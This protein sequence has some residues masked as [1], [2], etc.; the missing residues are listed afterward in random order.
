MQKTRQEL[1][2]IRA[3]CDKDL[4][5]FTRFF[6]K[7]LRG[8]KFIVNHHHETIRNNLNKIENYELELLNINIP[9]RFSKC[10][11][12]DT[13][14]M[15]AEGLK[16]A[17]NVTNSDKLYTYDQGNL[18]IEQCLGTETAY[19]N[20]VK[21]TMRS[22]RAITCST[23]HPML[24]TFGYKEA[25]D[26]S[27]G[28]RIKAIRTKIDA[29]YEIDYNE[30][31][32][33]T[34]MIFEGNCYKRNLRFSNNDK[35]IVDLFHKVC[36]ELKIGVKQ[37]D[38]SASYDYN[39]LGGL[40]GNAFNILQKYGIY[41][42]KSYTKRL[43]LDWFNL[44]YGQ[45]LVFIDLMFATDGYVNSSNGS[46]GVCLANKG[47][48]VDI[49]QILATVGIISTIHEKPNDYAGAWSLTVTRFETQKLTEM[50]SFYHKR[51]KAM[52]SHNNKAVFI[53]DS[54]PY[55]II[56]FEK[57]TYKTRKDGLRCE[58]TKDITREKFNRLR[59]KYECLNK[60]VDND[61][62]LDK[63]V[64]IEKVGKKKL[65]HLE[66][67]RTKNFIANGLVSHNTELAAVNL[68]ARG[69]GMNPSSNYLY[70][71]ASDELRSQTSVS[72]RDIVTHPYF[73]IMYGVELKKDQ[74]AKN[75]WRTEQGGGLKTATIFGQITGFGAGQMKLY[76]G[77]EDLI[78]DFEGCIVIDDANKTD[79]SEVENSN[80]D[81]VSRVFFNTILSRKN[82][83]DTPI[84]NIQQRAGLSDLTAQLEEHYMGN[85]KCEFLVMPVITDG[86]PLWEWKHNVNDIH[87][88]K[89]SPKTAHVFETQYMQNPQPSEGVVFNKNELNRFKL[90]DLDLN[91]KESVLGAIDVA[92][93]GVDYLSF[94]IGYL[95]SD[96]IY[97]TDWVFTQENME[98]TIPKCGQAINSNNIDHCA[99]ETNNH[100]HA[101]IRGVYQN[102]SKSNIIPVNQTAKKHSRIINHAQFIRMH[103]VFRSDYAEGSE[104]DKAMKLLFRYLKDGSFK[105]DDAPD[106][107][108]LLSLLARK[109]FSDR[110]V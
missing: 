16:K 12:E 95:Y 24:T 8:S 78:R 37:Y 91:A 68:I 107:L 98:Y 104:Y 75:L 99:I 101:F 20:S 109:L 54:F 93:K 97:I 71:T 15:T 19:K 73:K 5:F 32:F 106:S 86:V 11:D 63:V 42:H 67:N 27:V 21:I 92:D 64:S 56:P 14:I 72:I 61:F 39:L 23:D 70:I 88:L 52:T 96:K 44:S 83:R 100:G 105:K 80:N 18:T 110:F 9:P 45:K 94:P 34:L 51:D 47:L 103:F 7:E 85:P 81:K 46:S 59:E 3:K 35:V 50:I 29:D 22:G 57:L 17:V 87:E 25:K 2:L 66:V 38:S 4:L 76:D 79:D 82:S 90:S 55:E 33:I 10:V 53:T 43:P 102:V 26:I 40:S 13:M 89:T 69:I 41:G 28:E 36:K 1:A 48:I 58:S 77:L 62:Y 84:I 60:Y 49:Q 74:N 31:V 65:I 30:L 6:Y 108:A